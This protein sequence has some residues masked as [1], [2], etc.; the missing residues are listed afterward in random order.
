MAA[1]QVLQLAH[2][3]W[4]CIAY[5]TEEVAA[6]VLMFLQQASAAAKLDTFLESV[7]ATK[8]EL[9]QKAK[10][11]LLSSSWDNIKPAA[12][13]LL[14]RL[15]STATVFKYARASFRRYNAQLR[16]AVLDYVKSIFE[17]IYT[18]ATSVAEQ[19]EHV[20]YLLASGWGD[21]L[22]DKAVS[23]ETC[24][25]RQV[26]VIMED[27]LTFMSRK[28][29]SEYIESVISG[30]VQ[31]HLPTNYTVKN[32]RTF[33]NICDVLLKRHGHILPKHSERSNNGHEVSQNGISGEEGT[34]AKKAKYERET[35]SFAESFSIK[36]QVFLNLYLSEA[37]VAEKIS[38]ETH[39]DNNA[40]D[41]TKELAPLAITNEP[42]LLQKLITES[43]SSNARVTPKR[44]CDVIT[45]LVYRE[46][47]HR[48]QPSTLSAEAERSTDE[49]E[50]NYVMLLED[51]H[52]LL[53]KSFT[54]MKED[55]EEELISSLMTRFSDILS[56]NELAKNVTDE[57]FVLTSL[58]NF[59]QCVHTVSNNLDKFSDFV[60]D[61]RKSV[62]C[63]PVQ[64]DK[65]QFILDSFLDRLQALRCSDVKHLLV[66]D[67]YPSKE[68]I[69]C[70]LDKFC[71]EFKEKAEGCS[72]YKR[73]G[74]DF[75]RLRNHGYTPQNTETLASLVQSISSA[76]KEFKTSSSSLLENF[77]PEETQCLCRIV[78]GGL[79]PETPEAALKEI[80]S[81]DNKY[82]SSPIF[83]LMRMLSKQIVLGLFETDSDAKNAMKEGS[84]RLFS[85]LQTWFLLER[86]FDSDDEND[87]TALDCF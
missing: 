13:R 60:F 59:L 46:I 87:P 21:L 76:C 82:N 65:S 44:L 61:H 69:S 56:Q 5:K 24:N 84:V 3:L 68:G 17:E 34:P 81:E 27:L 52:Q 83:R 53:N 15:C 85:Q 36:T 10:E 33:Y 38:L 66:K 64:P 42:T 50:R 78:N 41:S 77:T 20:M 74:T 30:L 47:L 23:V 7:S 71:R 80:V 2:G 29:V 79:D 8:A 25:F 26:C 9:E 28:D 43:L 37:N 62:M 45:W 14:S 48:L 67:L 16:V 63:Q 35:E 51:F 55:L 86:E 58:V 39:V 70:L 19:C 11:F 12:F 6:Q 31:E 75:T 22:L 72:G 4:Q 18:T 32:A 57:A 1:P 73:V 40:F 49:Y 54:D